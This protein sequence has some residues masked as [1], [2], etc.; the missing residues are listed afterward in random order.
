[1]TVDYSTYESEKMAFIKKHG[2]DFRVITSPMDEYGR[3]TKVYAYN[4]GCVFFQEIMSPFETHRR[5]WVDEFKKY[6]DVKLDLLKIEF[7][8]TDD[9]RSKYCYE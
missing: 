9:S 8:S 2:G 3:Y 7:F 4:N 5:V 6:A 1:M